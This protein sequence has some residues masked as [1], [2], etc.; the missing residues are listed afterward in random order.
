MKP[1]PLPDIPIGIMTVLIVVAD[2]TLIVRCLY[3]ASMF[4]IAKRISKKRFASANV[5]ES[6][7]IIRK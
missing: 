3:S 7:K 1:N 5:F 2:I 6:N 4:F